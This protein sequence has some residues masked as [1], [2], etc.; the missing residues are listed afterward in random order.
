MVGVVLT[1]VHVGVGAGVRMVVGFVVSAQV[2]LDA[3]TRVQVW[4]C[5]PFTCGWGCSGQR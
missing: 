2:S 1:K 4:V 3:G 5:G